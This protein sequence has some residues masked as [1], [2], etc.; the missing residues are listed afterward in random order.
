MKLTL[1]IITA[2]LLSGPPAQ[3]K[4]PVQNLSRD[5]SNK[6]APTIKKHDVTIVMPPEKK[7]YFWEFAI[8]SASA[9]GIAAAGYFGT[10][11]VMHKKRPKKNQSAV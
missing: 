2:L 1:I 11:K 4:S 3:E 10:R 6:K 9:L 7:N 5:Y 8:A